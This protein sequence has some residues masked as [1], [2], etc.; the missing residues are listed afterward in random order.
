MSVIKEF[1]EAFC[2]E[3]RNIHRRMIEA[4]EQCRKITQERD[5]LQIEL[6]QARAKNER[7]KADVHAATQNADTLRLSVIELR[8]EKKTLQE[9]LAESRRELASLFLRPE[10][11]QLQADYAACVQDR[12]RL[13]IEIS[14]LRDAVKRMHADVET[15][16]FRAETADAIAKARHEE[17]V[18]AEQRAAKAQEVQAEYGLT[19]GRLRAELDSLR[20]QNEQL[21]GGSG[22]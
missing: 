20:D 18:A 12:E 4:E 1:A 21:R 22:R 19:I 3:L 5:E 10:L 14:A 2:E 9:E 13:N 8:G 17:R 6:A 16:K 15:S 7:L 11:E